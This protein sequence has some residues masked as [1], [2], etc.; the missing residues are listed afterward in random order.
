[1]KETPQRSAGASGLL[2]MRPGHL[3]SQCNTLAGHK[4][5]R[6]SHIPQHIAK[7]GGMGGGREWRPRVEALPGGRAPPAGIAGTWD[8]PT[9]PGQEEESDRKSEVSP[10]QKSSPPVLGRPA[11]RGGT[12]TSG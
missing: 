6:T 9:A 2:G 5:G 11:P 1:M 10:Q 12:A 7:P 4:E 8:S 3:R